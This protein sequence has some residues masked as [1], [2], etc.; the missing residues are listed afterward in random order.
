MPSLSA[1]RG[2]GAI[3]LN[4]VPPINSKFFICTLTHGEMRVLKSCANTI[5]FSFQGS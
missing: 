4:E 1:A 5:F 2:A 3:A